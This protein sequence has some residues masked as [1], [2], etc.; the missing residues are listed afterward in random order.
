MPCEDLGKNVMVECAEDRAVLEAGP[1]LEQK[2]LG[3]IEFLI[4]VVDHV[5]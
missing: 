4:S 5:V 1:W 2:D 3:R